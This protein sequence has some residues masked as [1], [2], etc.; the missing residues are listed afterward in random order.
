MQKALMS[1]GIAAPLVPAGSLLYHP[2]VRLRELPEA[3]DRL[4]PEGSRRRQGHIG[5]DAYA[6]SHECDE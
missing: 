1:Y 2:A 5:M 6:R 4:T 3:C